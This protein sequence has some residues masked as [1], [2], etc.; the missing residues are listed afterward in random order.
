MVLKTSSGVCLH[1]Y[2]FNLA[3]GTILHKNVK[4]WSLGTDSRLYISPHGLQ[5]LLWMMYSYGDHKTDIRLCHFKVLMDMH[6]LENEQ[7]IGHPPDKFTHQTI[8]PY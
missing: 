1:F 2:F 8:E 5:S 6:G 7:R 4:F 3:L